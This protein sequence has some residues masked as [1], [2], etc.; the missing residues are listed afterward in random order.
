MLIQSV[1]AV[2]PAP[3]RESGRPWGDP[4]ATREFIHCLFD[5][6]YWANA[7][8]LSTAA[9]LTPEQLTLKVLPHHNSVR[10]TF[11]HTL[12][13][14]WIWLE[15]WHGTSPASGLR[16][17]DFPTL[18]AIRA[19]WQIEQARLR[20]FLDAQRD[21]DLLRVVS[22]T[23]LKGQVFAFPLWQLMAHV[24][25]HGTQHR[26]EIAAMLTELG[27]SPGDMDLVR[28]YPEWLGSVQVN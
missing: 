2:W 7:R 5:Y 23:N 26:S 1:K 24:V 4:M 8:L 22:Y 25:N 3:V 18:D 19:R 20:V 13:A 9:N 14:E 15:R 17:E 16:E 12:S 6:H 28:F 10:G 27:H 21:E 11:V